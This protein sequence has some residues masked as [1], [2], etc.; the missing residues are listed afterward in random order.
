MQK[1]RVETWTSQYVL[2]VTV[3]NKRLQGQFTFVLFKFSCKM[4]L[5]TS[6]EKLMIQLF[7]HKS[8]F[9]DALLKLRTVAV[10]YPTD[11]LAAEVLLSFSSPRHVCRFSFNLSSVAVLLIL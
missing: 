2:G 6:Y 5:V 11:I 4:F 1:I 3:Y 8:Y 7:I 10:S 9:N